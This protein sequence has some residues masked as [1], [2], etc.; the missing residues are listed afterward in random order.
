MLALLLS[1]TAVAADCP[2]PVTPAEVAARTDDAQLAWA[3]LDEDGFIEIVDALPAQIGCLDGVLDPAQAAAAHRMLA[4]RA[5]LS[6][7][8]AATRASVQ[9]ATL[10]DPG[11]RLSDRIAPEGGKLWR[12]YDEASKQAAP[13]TRALDL[14]DGWTTWVDGA[15]TA[16]RAQ[17]LPAVVQIGASADDL[18]WTGLVPY[19]GTLS[20]PDLGRGP[21]G[22][23]DLDAPPPPSAKAR[24][25]NTPL[26]V[27]AGTSGAVAAGLFGA[28][29][30]LRG[31]FDNDPSKGKYTAVN[32]TF[33]GS[34]GMTA[35][36]G[37]L[38]T[39]ALVRK[40]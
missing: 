9:A 7:D 26:W 6:D 37:G 14:P 33:L 36:T 29:A 39:A 5:F 38:V 19:D 4:L 18:R 27:A 15:Q 25:S 24:S 31:S 30:G 2:S 11:Y 10:A 22:A 3:T 12:L 23:T 32:A 20:L 34:M 8:E 13:K 16:D 17:G 21:G 28:S 40:R 35:L 1:L